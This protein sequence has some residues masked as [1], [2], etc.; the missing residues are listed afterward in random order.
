MNSA[1]IT[2]TNGLSDVRL[3]NNATNP[4]ALTIFAEVYLPVILKQN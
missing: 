3:A 4:L 1:S 2:T